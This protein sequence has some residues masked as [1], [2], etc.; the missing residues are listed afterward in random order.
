MADPSTDGQDALRLLARATRALVEEGRLSLEGLLPA[1]RALAP[2]THAGARADAVD[3]DFIRRCRALGGD[4]LLRARTIVVEEGPA[5]STLRVTA[6]AARGASGDVAFVAPAGDA[7]P[8]DALLLA[9][10]LSLEAAKLAHGLKPPADALRASFAT[11]NDAR[12]AVA[13]LEWGG[14]AR[15]LALA[16]ARPRV[17]PRAVALHAGDRPVYVVCGAGALR[18]HDLL[19]PYARRL[20]AELGALGRSLRDAGGRADDDDV[21]AGAAALLADDE[22]CA[23]RLEAERGE[24]FLP[25]GEGAL[26]IRCEAVPDDVDRRCREAAVALKRARAA[27]VVVEPSAASLAA[28][29]EG[30]GASCR[31][32]ALIHEADRAC[33][34][35]FVRECASGHVV[36]VENALQSEGTLTTLPSLG[37]AAG[38][39]DGARDAGAFFLV[40]AALQ[41]QAGGALSGDAR[42]ALKTYAAGD[43]QGMSRAC[44]DVLSRLGPKRGKPTAAAPFSRK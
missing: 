33:V 29:L 31:A 30:A 39:G 6:A 42:V 23:E 20:R 44:L 2:P 37:L 8:G 35:R 26:V 34:P 17:D 4:A 9:L 21:Y 24:G 36:L 28:A 43:V 40:Q 1:Y 15:E 22:V 5:R 16:P 10:G 19:S 41:A 13:A 38:D 12:A 7:A 18:V 11:P 25:A 32:V 3:V 27:I 14:A